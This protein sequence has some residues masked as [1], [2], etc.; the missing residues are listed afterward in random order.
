MRVLYK[1]C[2]LGKPGTAQTP[3]QTPQRNEFEIFPRTDHMLVTG[4][5]GQY[6][7]G[8]LRFL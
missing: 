3:L 8:F 6:L 5:V 2:I 1:V 4:L 7:R